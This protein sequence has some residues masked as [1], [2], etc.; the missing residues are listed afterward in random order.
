MKTIRQNFTVSFAYDVAFTRGLFEPENK[1]FAECIG[2]EPGKPIPKLLFVFDETMHQHHPALFDNIR[3]YSS[4]PGRHFQ[5]IE[6]YVSIPGGE[7]SK[8]NPEYV[9]E[10]LIAVEKADLDRHSYVVVAG[11]GAVIDTAGY[12]AAIAHRGVRLIRIPTT[13]LAQNDAAIGVKNGINAFD[14]KN[15]LGTFVPPHAVL[16]DFDFLNTLNDRDWRAGISESVKVA[17]IKDASFFKKL[18]IDAEKLSNRDSKSMEDLIIRCAELHLEHISTSGDPFES[19]SS[20]PLDFGHWAAHKLEQLTEYEL[21]HGEA[22]AIGIALDSLYSY[23]KGMISKKDCNRVINLFKSCG[24]RMYVP[25]LDNELDNPDRKESIL[26]GLEEFREHLG[27]EL[28]IMLLQG[29]GQ[30]IEVHE[31]DTELYKKAV[32]ILRSTEKQPVSE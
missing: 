24:F 20:R 27:G 19:G 26:Y 6:D 8:N 28:T 16:N 17:L 32:E 29:I 21:R 31:V 9:E 7:E 18:E 10:I 23:L 30:G 12:A 3:A 1:L 15:F 14:K 2:Y 11:G 22:V 25:E 4:K 5:L 13:V